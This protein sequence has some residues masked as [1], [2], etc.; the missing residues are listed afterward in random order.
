MTMINPIKQIY[1][2]LLNES[3]DVWRPI[4]AKKIGGRMYLIL[5]QPYDSNIEDWEFKPGE[6]V[7]CEYF[8]SS[9]GRILVA[10]KR[11]END[12]M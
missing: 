9:E 12:Q 8:D 6:K 1:V 3:V 10:K 11:D 5:P 4:K 2:A 7:I